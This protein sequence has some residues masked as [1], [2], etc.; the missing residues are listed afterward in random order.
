MD[1]KVLKE[2]IEA[3]SNSKLTSFEVE[4]NGV[5]IKMN[6]DVKVVTVEKEDVSHKVID[7]TSGETINR[8]NEINFEKEHI[9][10]PETIKPEAE[11]AVEDE[12]LEVVVSP[13]VGTFYGS[14]GPEEKSFVN[15]GDKVKKGDTLCIIEAM[16]LMNE[17]NAEIDGEI[18][19]I[20]VDNEQMVEYG[21]PIMKI[22]K[23]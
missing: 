19:E 6:K 5:K 13:I 18:V 21:Q 4:E 23:G 16:K 8:A 3:V 15:K 11:I 14:P 9:K 20:L 7:R 2:L 1:Y 12:N 17:I 22:R 10:T